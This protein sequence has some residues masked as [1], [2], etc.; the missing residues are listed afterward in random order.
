MSANPKLKRDYVWLYRG[1]GT[2]S[3]WVRRDVADET[4]VAAL[5]AYAARTVPEKRAA[6][7]VPHC[8]ATYRR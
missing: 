2:D 7:S 6:G 5:R 1:E 3:D 4:G 8:T